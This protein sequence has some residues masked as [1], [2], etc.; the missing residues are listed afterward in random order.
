MKVGIY[1][2]EAFPVYEVHTDGFAEIEVDEDTLKKWKEVFY[3]FHEV[4]CDIVAHMKAQGHAD[5]V[6]ANGMW[7]G[8]CMGD[9]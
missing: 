9:D 3:K 8:F 4:Q 7:Y 2:G 5:K 6:W 1:G